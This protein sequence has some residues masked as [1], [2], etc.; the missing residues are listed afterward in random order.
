M[1]K[2]KKILTKILLG[3]GVMLF[4]FCEPCILKMVGPGTQMV[5]STP[6]KGDAVGNYDTV[7]GKELM[8]LN[9]LLKRHFPTGW[10][11]QTDT[12]SLT[13]F[14]GFRINPVNQH[15]LFHSGIDIKATWWEPVY[16]TAS[17]K[18]TFS[19]WKGGYGRAITINHGIYRTLY[20][21]LQR[22]KIRTGDF[23]EKG[24]MIGYAGASGK[25]TGPH[26]H[27]EVLK[28]GLHIDPMV[29]VLK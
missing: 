16:A 4:L 2:M 26:L 29:F 22:A 11:I 20:A 23:V 15:G 19:G 9:D 12:H 28:N 18:V 21:H 13:S 8:H 14:Y 7:L 3:A 5:A 10:P 17:G 25:T 6:K 24:Q 27:Y 1:R